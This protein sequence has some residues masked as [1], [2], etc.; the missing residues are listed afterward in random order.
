MWVVPISAQNAVDEYYKQGPLVYEDH[1]YKS[2]IRTV[3]LY[4]IGSEFRMPI[5][6]LNSMERLQLEFDDLFEDYVDYSYRIVHCD[7]NWTPSALMPAQ[8][9]SNFQDFILTQFE[10]STNA[11]IPYTNYRLSIP[12]EQVRLTKSGNYLLIIYANGNK[13]DLVLSRRFMLYEDVVSVGGVVRRS[14]VVDN[15]D[16]HQEIDFTL[17]H[18]NYVIQNPFRDLQVVVMQNQRYDNVIKNLK[19]RFVQNNQL[20]YN[21][22]RENNFAGINEFRFFDTKNLL[23]LTQNIRR[24]NRDSVYTVFMKTDE[25]KT[26]T[27]YTVWDDLNGQYVIRRL[28]ATNSNTEADYAYV[29]FILDYPIPS[30]EGDIYLFGKF[31]DWKLLPEYKLQYDYDRSAYR[32]KILLKQGYYNYVYALSKDGS[33]SADL[34]LM[35]GDHWETENDYQVLIYNREVGIRYDRLVGF[36]TLSSQDLY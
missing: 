29:D 21:Y 9:L 14:S 10:Y 28:D 5:I 36:G 1:V 19:P 34:S 24:V 27:R 31:T 12:N 35:E 13:E 8:Y 15:Y 26:I 32:T 17:S 23:T 33:F 22:D 3:R 30:E 20:D 2:G 7:A 16:T 18:P 6:R 11:L 25:P 4:P